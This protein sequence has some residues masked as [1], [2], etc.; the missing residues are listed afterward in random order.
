MGYKAVFRFVMA[1][2]LAVAGVAVL[3]GLLTSTHRQV[4]AA[5]SQPARP[6]IDPLNQEAASDFVPQAGSAWSLA[7]GPSAVPLLSGDGS[8]V[9]TV[10]LSGEC[11]Y[12]S[13]QAAV[14]AAPAGAMVKVAQ[15]VYTDDDSDGVV[16]EITKSLTLRG[17]YT[18]T[19]WIV[20]SLD[21]YTTALDGEG[22]A[23]V[24][25][26]GGMGAGEIAPTVEGFHIRNGHATGGG[27]DDNGGGV[28]VAGGDAVVRR[29]RIYD[30]EATDDGG[31]V[32]VVDDEPT[33]ENNLIFSNTASLGGGGGVYVDDGA[34]LLRHN[35]LYGNQSHDGG[36]G[37]YVASA[38]M[39]V[40][41]ATVV[42]SNVAETPGSGGGIHKAGTLTVTLGYNDVWGN[43][44]LQYV[45]VTGGTG[46]I[47]ADPLF[48]D[49]ANGT[50]RLQIDSPCIDQVPVAQT[51]GLDYDGRARPFGET[52]DIGAYEFYDPSTCYARVATGRVYTTVQQAVD[53]ATSGDWIQVAGLCQGV[54]YRKVG[55]DTFTQTVCITQGLTLRG[56]YTVSNWSDPDP[57]VY[58]TTLDA[59]GL[60]RVVY[61]NS[62]AEVTVEGFH[63]RNGSFVDGGG[64]YL[65]G[66]DHVVR[67][68]E[69][70]SNTVSGKGGGIYVADSNPTVQGNSIYENSA[71]ADVNSHGGGVHCQAGNGY[72]VGNAIYSNTASGEGGGLSS[73]T[74][75]PMIS[76]N[77]ISGNSTSNHGGGIRIEWGNP[78]V[79]DNEVYNNVAGFYGGGLYKASEAGS[80][81]VQGNDIYANTAGEGGG[82]YDDNAEGS[83]MLLQ[84]NNIFSNTASGPGG[85]VSNRKSLTLRGNRIYSNT[86]SG[87]GG[88][89]YQY[90][91]GVGSIEVQG[92]VISGN[93]AADGGGIYLRDAASGSTILVENNLVYANT[94]DGGDGGGMYAHSALWDS[95]VPMLRNNTIYGNDGDGLYA[96]SGM[97]AGVS[98]ISNT[99]VVS[100]TGYGVRGGSN[101]VAAYCNVWG[102]LSGDYGGGAISGT[103]AVTGTPQFVD[104]GVDFHL[105]AG[106]P[107]VDAAD[108]GSGHHP[109]EDY[110]GV[111]RPIGPRA[112]IGA[113][114]FRP[115]TCFARVGDAGQVYTS[116]QQAVGA[117][118]PG[119]NVRVAGT[120]QDVSSVGVDGTTITQ[121]VYVSRELTLRG[122]YTLTNW[123]TPTTQTTLGAQGQG[124][125]VY[126]TGTSA[127][128]VDGFVIRDGD[129]ITGGGI[130]VA[131]TGLYPLI[132]N[133]MFHGNRADYGGGFGAVGGSPQLYNNTFVSNTANVD[134]GGLYLGGGSPV[135]SNTIVVSNTS[136]S[137]SAAVPV[138]LAYCDVWGN[139]GCD[140]CPNV[141]QGTGS[142]SGDPLF[143]N[144]AGGDFHLQAD[145][146]CVHK[147][148]PGTALA[149]DF[150]GDDRPLPQGGGCDVGADES[151]TFRSVIL[152]P[153]RVRG[154][155]P[156]QD[157]VHIHYL[158]NTGSIA[159]TFN[160]SHTLEVSGT[161]TGWEPGYE[162]ALTLASG[163]WTEVPFTM[164][165]PEDA[166]VG[167]RAV[168][169]LTATS[170]LVYD[171][172]T[173][174]TV[175]SL[176]RGVD[177]TPSYTEDINPGVVYTYEHTLVNGG[178]V[179]DDFYVKVI[180]SSY[181]WAGVTPGEVSLG[182]NQSAPV[183]VT[184]T[185]PYT[186]PGGLVETTVVTVAS[187]NDHEV[188]DV[189]TD[190]TQVNHTPGTRYVSP[191]GTDSFNNCLVYTTTCR[192]VRYAVGQAASGDTIKVA[193]GTYAETE[194]YLNKDVTLLGGYT[195]DDWDVSDPDAN[196]TTLD[197]GRMGRVMRIAGSP[198]VEG[199]RLQNG[200]TDG[201]GGGVYIIV[202]GPYLH[203]N[204]ISSCTAA[205]GGGV[206]N[207]SLDTGV[208]LEGN[209]FYSNTASAGGGFYNVG[210][211]VRIEGNEF[212]S[213]T[214]TTGGG[215]YNAQG[216]PLLTQNVFE[217]NHAGGRGGAVYVAGGGPTLERAR[218]AFNVAD[219]GGG[220]ATDS[221]VPDLWNNLV[222]RNVASADGGGI[223]VVSGSPRIWHN[224]VYTNSAERGGGLYLAGGSPAVSNT[225]VVSNAA[226]IAG[227]GV[228]SQAA[229]AS[230]DE[231]DV[232]G[233]L[234][235]DTFGLQ[236]GVAWTTD[237]LFVDAGGFD[238]RL[239]L[240]SP[241]IDQGAGGPVSQDYWGDPRPMGE[242]DIGADEV[243]RAGVALTPDHNDS[244]APGVVVSYTHVL[245]NEGNY[246]DTFELTWQ[247]E[248]ESWDVK[249]NDATS[250]PILVTLES[251]ETRPV[252]VTV[253]VPGSGVISGTV[254]TTVVTA[255]SQ[256]NDSVWATTVNT[257]TVEQEALVSLE[258]DYLV[259]DGAGQASVGQSASYTHTL[260]NA[261]NYTDTFILDAHSSEGLTV[262]LSATEAGPLSM[263]EEMTIQV[264]VTVPGGMSDFRV[265]T[266]VVTATSQSAS[267]GFDTAVDMTFI[268]RDVGVEIAPDQEG[269]SDPD[270]SVLYTHILTNTGDYT[271]TFDLSLYTA[272]GWGSLLTSSPVPDVGPGMTATVDVRV[273]VPGGVAAGTQDTTI[274]T[275]TSDFSPTVAATT[276]DTT[277]VNCVVNPVLSLEEPGASAT[278]SVWSSA[279]E[280]VYATYTHTLANADSNCTGFF[281]LAVQSSPGFTA[282]VF[283]SSVISLGAGIS[284]TVYVTVT[285]PV[286]P[287]GS[288][289]DANL[290]VDHT[291]L[292]ATDVLS[293]AVYATALDTTVVNRCPDMLFAPETSMGS[294]QPGD[295]VDYA[296]TLTNTSN[297]T[298]TF[299][300]ELSGWGSIVAPTENPVTLGPGASQVVQV[301]V[302]V[303]VSPCGTSLATAV[304]A[305][306]GFSPTL[307]ATVVDT[308]TVEHEPSVAMGV[309]QTSTVNSSDTQPVTVTY[310]HV[311]SN[312]SNC[313]DTFEVTVTNSLG[314]AVAVS[315]EDLTD[316]ASGDARTVH[317]TLTVPV[318]TPACWN[319]LDAA[320]VVTATSGGTHATN[321]DT[322]IV[323]R[324][325]SATLVPDNRSIITQVA[326]TELQLPYSHTLTNTGNYIDAFIVTATVQTS[327][328][329]EGWAAAV[330]QPTI[331]GLGSGAAAPVEVEV[332]V[333]PDAYTATASTVVTATSLS[334][335]SGLLVYT[336]TATSVNTTTVR[337]P[338]VTL[339]PDRS[340]NAAAGAA[341]VYT[342]TLTNTGGLT[343]T[344]EVTATNGLGWM[345]QVEPTAVYTLPPGSVASVTATVEVP[346]TALS[347]T[348]SATTITAT[349]S[350]TDAV[351][352]TVV[353]TVTVPY[354]PGAAWSSIAPRWA[355]PGETVVYTHILTN[356]GNYTETF[357]LSLH[358]SEL[359]Y[360]QR[361]P[362]A[363]GPLG[364]G[365]SASDIRVTV[366]VLPSAASGEQD[367][368][369][370]IADFRGVDEQV[371]VVDL[372]SIN[373]VSG[374]RH[375]APDGLDD[376]SNCLFASDPCATMQHAVDQAVDGDTVKVAAGLYAD[377]HLVEGTTQV[378]K[379]SESITLTGGYAT[380][381]WEASDPVAR[382]TVLE[383]GGSGQR[384]AYV[385]GGS[386][387]IEG[388]HL[389]QG[390][391]A[392]NGAGLYISSDGTPVVRRNLIYSNTATGT[393]LGGGVH[394]VGSGDP[395][396]ERNTVFYNTA[397][398]GAGF[399]VNAVGSPWMW[400]N[401][402]YRNQASSSGGG[403]YNAAGGALIWNSTFYSN[404]AATGGGLFLAGAPI[405]SNTIVVRNAGHGIGGTAGTLAYNDVWGNSTLNYSG[406]STGTASISVDPRFV[407]AAGGD[408]HLRGDS[409]VINAGD[410][411]S[412]QPLDDREGNPRPLLGGYDIGAY[413]YNLI[414]AKAFT[415]PGGPNELI[416]YTIV[417][418][419]VGSRAAENVPITDTLHP[420]LLPPEEGAIECQPGSCGYVSDTRT[421]TW[422]GP[423]LAAT[424]SFVTFT[425]R[426]T[427]W[428]A[429]GTS[430]TNVAWVN[431]TPTAMVATTV[432]DVPGVRYVATTGGD[433]VSYGAGEEAG[434]NCLKPDQ[435]CRTVQYA[436]DQALAGDTV[437]V[438]T[439]VYTG[440]GPVVSVGKAIT[441]TG[442]YSPTEDWAYDPDAYQTTLSG[443]NA[444]RGLV[445][446]GSVTVTVAGFH[447]TDGASAAGGGVD[448]G[449]STVAIS[450]CRVY[451]NTGDGVHVS[452]GDL[453]LERTW[454]YSNTGD[455]AEVENGTYA[456]DNSVV[457][458]N[459]GA[460]LQTTDSEGALRHNTF[461][462]NGGAGAVVSGT[463]RFTNTILYSHAVGVSVT[464]GSTAILSNTLWYANTDDVSDG[465][466]AGNVVSSTNV[467]SDPVFVA[468]DAVDYHIQAGSNAIDR[469]IDTGLNG[470]ID[471][472][473]RW[474]L[475][476]PEI[477]ADEFPLAATKWAPPNADPGEVI[478]Y[479]IAL[480]GEGTLVLTDT[481]D[482]RLSY[483][484][485]VACNRGD[486][487]YLAL[488]RAIT[489]TGSIAEGQPAYITYTAQVTT[490]LAAGV[491]I[492][493]D[494]DVLMYGDVRRSNEATTE[495]NGVG[496]TRYVA[497]A[498]QGDDVDNSC[499]AGWR[500]CATMQHAV[501][502][503][504]AG[505]EVRVAEGT[506]V[507]A[508]PVVHV[509]ESITVTGGYTTPNWITSDPELHPVYVD[510]RAGGRAMVIT[511]PVTVTVDGL[512]L[513][514]G[515]VS[516]QGGGLYIH[517]AAVT[518]ANSQ[519]YSNVASGAGCSGG[520][521]YAEGGD[522]AIRATQVYSNVA[523]GGGGGVYQGG[524]SFTLDSSYVYS[525]G[526]VTGA[527]LFLK[528]VEVFLT[529]NRIF[530]NTSTALGG[531]LYISDT[532]VS[533][534]V[535]LLERNVIVGNYA[536]AEGG[537]IAVQL[538]GGDLI[539]LTNNVVAANHS[540]AGGDGLYLWGEGGIAEGHL[541]H[542][543]VA[544][545]GEHGLRVG[546]FI[547]AMSNTVL[548]SHTVGITT[549]TG[550]NVAADHTLWHATGSYTDTAGGGV[551]ATVNDL[552][553]DPK[554][555][556]PAGGDYHIQG[557]SAAVGAGAWVGVDTDVDGEARLSTSDPDIGADQY[558]LR[559]AR[560]V[561][562]DREHPG[563][564]LVLC[565][566][567]THTLAL[568][569]VADSP[570]A[571]V[572]LTD[573]LPVSVAY[574]AYTNIVTYT[575]GSGGYVSGGGAQRA[576][577]WTGDVAAQSSVYITY[578][579]SITPYLAD[580]TVITFTGSVSDSVSVF[581]VTPLPVTVRT[582]VGAVRKQGQGSASPAGGVAIG[583]PVTYTVSF[584][585][586][587]GH[588]AYRPVVVEQLPRVVEGGVISTTPAVTYVVGSLSVN[589]TYTET[590]DR[591]TGD[592]MITWTLGTVTATCGGPELVTLAF[593]ARVL[594]RPGNGA[595]DLLTNTVAIS[596]TEGSA[597]GLGRV[598][599]DTHALTL[600]E[601]GLMVTH[602]VARHENLGMDETVR[603]T[604][605]AVNTGTGSLHD[606]T[607]TDTLQG[608]WAVSDT[609]GGCFTQTVGSIDAG[610]SVS[611]AF[612][613]RVS[614][615][616]GPAVVLTATAEVLG[617]SLPDAGSHGVSYTA[618]QA[619][620][621]TTG[622][623]DLSIDKEGSPVRSPG[624]VITYA[625]HYANV[626][627]VRA[628][629][630]RITDTLPL[631]L[632]DVIS[633]T[634][635][636]TTVER[637]GRG[638]TWTLTAPVSR[639]I[640]GP[641]GTVWITATVSTAIQSETVLTNTA[642][643]STTTTETDTLGHVDSATTTVR[644]PTLKITKT[645]EPEEVIPG[646]VL[647]YTLIVSNSGEGDATGLVISDTVPSSTG[648]LECDGGDACA[649]DSGR[650]VVTWT[651]ALLPAGEQVSVSFA[652]RVDT[653]ADP[654]IPIRNHVFGASCVQGYTVLGGPVDT[655]IGC[656]PV[657]IQSI[658]YVPSEPMIG[659]EVT[660]TGVVEDAST[661]PIDYV[662]DFGDGEQV[663]LNAEAGT[664]SVVTHAY[665]DDGVYTVVFRATNACRVDSDSR[666]VIVNPYTVY[667]PLVQR[668]YV[669]G[670]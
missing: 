52:A 124:R 561:S 352:A 126:I 58:A 469:G 144:P 247:N 281:S 3:L 341:V 90:G 502:Q 434:S 433:A 443:R 37:V 183:W 649:H 33:L 131:S 424:P 583:E 512:R 636:D 391:I 495:I 253:A 459:A 139:E 411:D 159:D 254:N 656:V 102:N 172:V 309:A 135:V 637:I 504:Q 142:F 544:D 578:S 42:V 140:W 215:F 367:R 89:F 17:G 14:S 260:T 548:V 103:G 666:T 189:I 398:Y 571:G 221:S 496:G 646:G 449:P 421:V 114:E 96:V 437:K 264:T 204:T 354:K 171:V 565:Q 365:E 633:A 210:G 43:S 550:A 84:D 257:T 631:S 477:G 373:F 479:V 595:G 503:A 213:N 12:L 212:Y 40:I 332:T 180:S 606:V 628:E 491:Q 618:T 377:V 579:A 246:T 638:V 536:S 392:G 214:A 349:S 610:D 85:G 395:L 614:E 596:Y 482:Y 29:N 147:A 156:G 360:A 663:T 51:V 13:V 406:V 152:S 612:T 296:H 227:G 551:I 404:T 301:R 457:A 272:Q 480:E 170:G 274:V 294:G 514:N 460:G 132:Q 59:Q 608:G 7:G 642:G 645:T 635:A 92:N 462:R 232:W 28:Y 105:S 368:T 622:Y 94:A 298:D 77:V 9:I 216:D 330:S 208:L 8:S 266:T 128:T 21:V 269:N 557:D 574:D 644:L 191:S 379:V 95:C 547:L 154:G 400:N 195:T 598:V 295:N 535:G 458:H 625:I 629:D 73:A 356:T 553:G 155:L 546:N 435:P 524:G 428:L 389:R 68:N 271:D 311:V 393:G 111:G 478:T 258:P 222:Y 357:D 519:V 181:G 27:E 313:T 616:I 67:D 273:S 532:T 194:V 422:T 279:T 545:N 245:T 276:V 554:F 226:V 91:G 426:I 262:T 516:D 386:P 249:V 340:T 383:A 634:S 487:G 652:V 364:P 205:Q 150:E 4:Y 619:V 643:I 453:T 327:S 63:V 467:Y 521:I 302:G 108:P 83:C 238:L 334:Q 511:G 588:V 32:Y 468:P 1:V 653:D 146:P 178:N 528:D 110:D 451:S 18:T 624:Q 456:L 101:L 185:V 668:N 450:R 217:Y 407:D 539:T 429:A 141:S 284:T 585:V 48:E 328:P 316:L 441:L 647:T 601:P 611:V 416:T 497:M 498:P 509:S 19:D 233:N 600:T 297:Y 66:G 333:P 198:T 75:A 376:H 164:T 175:V 387:V 455:G 494:A 621:A 493:N 167:T 372:T 542:N 244:G 123:T 627:V 374:T 117:A 134:G 306:S 537:G 419:N 444:E 464:A 256:T 207:Y 403:L 657:S 268:N 60:G 202:G 359:V 46:S 474:L 562:A 445:V 620:T 639:S 235:G 219:Q 277:T 661:T 397:E 485:T 50:F 538:G 603:I 305:T 64:F 166:G 394:Y 23:R 88:G 567:L 665:E 526:A 572:R 324:C 518:L 99:I 527:G 319:L 358:S 517:T 410:P 190:T 559:A 655:P 231:N 430:I 289:P 56:G 439:G 384:V 641:G 161:G 670:P 461:A 617:T 412:T 291:V 100:N 452:G 2:C 31:G 331:S 270:A 285:V 224:T 465:A 307:S 507:G 378:V 116:V 182:P 402:V 177:F 109:S 351:Y 107:C 10:C 255:T 576:I 55:V 206:Y 492:V 22:S 470:D 632:T 541:R 153:F 121:T 278:Q 125:V 486:G 82:V 49:A 500:P 662:W 133:V 218:L 555:A 366:Y 431:Y 510:A 197:G 263:G 11:D 320:T 74:G 590:E 282:T 454:V 440:T 236:D 326:S 438:A 36:G 130:Y 448:V 201:G 650:G 62:A 237:P 506:Y 382:E 446:G 390:Q 396:L 442:G 599:S 466:H 165:V 148:D 427:D 388:F 223:Y 261:G 530:T 136:G 160:L 314:W 200:A 664:T 234:N 558:P 520:G 196:I 420:F 560:W 522:L 490:W 69:I 230:L 361:S 265:D 409:P 346:S 242:A 355:D 122:G 592:G 563:D 353:D 5:S 184:V 220:F 569:N 78:T 199:F 651:L 15:G 338:H 488:Q 369:Y 323:N 587:A 72:I 471:G 239:Q 104:P 336:P 594:A 151:T 564:E 252:T 149:W 423:V 158:T 179:L 173:N 549:E 568:T 193:A 525:N 417:V 286:T 312:T 169:T 586:P 163:E 630:V 556:G 325:V 381:D 20:P 87:S 321:V 405:V 344:H 303:P 380:D 65:A 575:V 337:R 97:P 348:V 473:P 604:V 118:S 552:V 127:V 290:M 626:G 225:I 35:T 499:R 41:S 573:T 145:S 137:V 581:S 543:T 38:G 243:F 447:I 505:D 71:D 566:T 26:I 648:Y 577:T 47:S 363:V 228:Y 347:N 533:G 540:G 98:M 584:T 168:V 501:D 57:D 113:Y 322:T 602:T 597:T 343:D 339:L 112:D 481:L 315:P 489:W 192:T 174:T 188:Q 308:T 187:K 250:Q 304:S 408:F 6:A 259:P 80:P 280:P 432:E 70:Y 143:V 401:V 589:G 609:G 425:A 288:C 287:P 25:Y 248:H 45:G 623:P 138:A 570:M 39:P 375:V 640:S 350:I 476:N 16:V 79:L 463:A 240:D 329:L 607:V 371:V 186:A 229:D 283:P 129:A 310:D 342:H 34:P 534:D 209:T 81:T 593:N 669:K 30:N 318:T 157:V 529:G 44:P 120:C 385:A 531:G 241:I 418:T 76:A 61:V 370:I 472:E 203:N 106:S 211:D 317:V 399:Y 162:S 93:T 24:I 523:G 267:S 293:P 582:A 475:V 115:G 483:T 362:V 176:Y 300:L 667:V 654:D 415:T 292:T 513:L 615:S 580:G 659:Q 436:V 658:T 53:A 508:D 613:A 605:T 251:G 335:G 484:G 591:S 413:Q 345:L 54:V 414:A 86:A 275:A 119:A 299:E 515:S 660:F